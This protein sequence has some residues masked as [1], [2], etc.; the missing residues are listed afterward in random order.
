MIFKWINV[1]TNVNIKEFFW[2]RDR[3]GSKATSLIKSYSQRIHKPKIWSSKLI[4]SPGL[5]GY[6]NGKFLSFTILQTP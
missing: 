4:S 2:S 3:K 5:G 1:Q 6:I